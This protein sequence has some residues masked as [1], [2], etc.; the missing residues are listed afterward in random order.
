MS[1]RFFRRTPLWP[2]PTDGPEPSR[3][4]KRRRG[5]AALIVVF[6]FFLFSALGLGTLDMTRTYL[7]VSAYRKNVLLLSYAAENGVKRSL[8]RVCAGLGRTPRP[9][10]LAADRLT[11]LAD[12][13]RAGG[14]AAAETAMSLNLPDRLEETSGDQSWTGTARCTM[15]RFTDAASYFMAEYRITLEAEGRLKNLAPSRGAALEMILKTAAGRIPLSYFSFLLTGPES[16]PGAADLLAS[17]KLRVL[18]SRSKDLAPRALVTPRPVLPQNPAELLAAAAKVR[19]LRPG[20][21]D[22]AELRRALG[23]EMIDAPIPDGVYLISGDVRPGGVFIQGDLDSLYL[24][25]AAGWQYLEFRSGPARWLLKFS[26]AA[27]KM[28]FRSPEGVTA[29]DRVPLG[30]ILVNG[31]IAVL[32]AARVDAG[33]E[34]SPVSDTEVPAVLDGAAL[35]IV[36]AGEI[37]IG[38]HLLHEGVKWMEDVPY[39]KDRS[40]Q[41]VVYAGGRDLIDGTARDGRIIIGAAA[42]P[43]VRIQASLT[44]ANGFAIDGGSRS[45]VLT[46]GLQTSVLS[47]GEG[48]LTIAP[49][50]RLAAEGLAPATGPAATEPVLF[51]LSLRPVAWT[52]RAP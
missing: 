40:S 47:L 19:F 22:R 9:L 32:S 17:D 51:V 52:E 33:E 12:D 48:R 42:P 44:A 35:T 11:A 4:A 7:K 25:A 36:S 1:L 46:G 8:N 34:L 2:V 15:D 13:A 23:L 38:S 37:T 45:V 14:T 20:E 18:P 27:G 29:A 50:E 49:D 3:P 10:P 43:D 39:L 31:A 26:P 6:A 41:L 28:E 21:L 16:G 30:M 24:A 5:S